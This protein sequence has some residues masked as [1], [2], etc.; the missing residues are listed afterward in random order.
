MSSHRME[1]NLARV[2]SRVAVSIK[3]PTPATRLGTL[4]PKMRRLLRE[5]PTR[6]ALPLVHPFPAP[7]SP[8]VARTI[9]ERIT[10][11]SGVVLDPMAGSGMVPLAALSLG[12]TCNALDIDPLALLT[13]KVQC[14]S[15]DLEELERVGRF[16]LLR[17]ERLVRRV[18]VLDRRLERDFDRPTRDFI[19]RWFPLKARRGLLALWQAIGE[20]SPVRLRDPLKIAFSHVI[21]AKT[22]GVSRAIDLPHTRPHRLVGKRVPD[23]IAMFPRRL[24][25][26]VQRLR[27]RG[28]M[29]SRATLNL[30]RGDVRRI[31]CSDGS[32]DLVLTSSPHANAIDYMRAHKF[33]LVW[34]GYSV[35]TL[36]NVRAQMI[37]AEQPRR[38]DG[39][40]GIRNQLV[41]ADGSTGLRRRAT[42]C[43]R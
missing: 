17:A 8:H 18:A 19:K 9:I 25:E 29:P 11:R 31:P 6:S 42:R 14:G 33:T 30:R 4:L 23:P 26:L 20:A 10:S 41:W 13:I 15:Y 1:R 16:T 34:M 3:R 37:G 38:A 40:D 43:R 28:P 32:V 35:S 2:E 5:S 36:A 21:I 12:R 7:L 24:H 39:A 27:E 22:A